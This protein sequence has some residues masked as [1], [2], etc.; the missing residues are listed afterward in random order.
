M[1]ESNTPQS[2][3]STAKDASQT[4]N[5]GTGSKSVTTGPKSA[6]TTNET[7]DPDNSNNPSKILA[8]LKKH[9]TATLV[10]ELLVLLVGIKVASIYSDQLG[11]MR[12]SVKIAHDTF[13][14]ANKPSVGIHD[15]KI[16]YSGRDKKGNAI[17]SLIP[18]KETDAFQFFVEIKN[19]GQMDERFYRGASSAPV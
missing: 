16:I 10:V 5:K 18:T 17:G 7:D 9:V 1:K 11:Q 19:F 4:K 6:P 2:Q 13:V 8:W 3:D 12:E 14:S 15:V